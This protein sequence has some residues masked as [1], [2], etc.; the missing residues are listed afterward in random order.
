MRFTPFLSSTTT[1]FPPTPNHPLNNLSQIP[2]PKQPIIPMTSTLRMH[3]RMI[4]ARVVDMLNPILIDSRE[5][6]GCT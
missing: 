3:I 5:G 1:L 2:P 4:G 6:L